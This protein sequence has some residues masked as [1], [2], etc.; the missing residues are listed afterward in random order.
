MI[1]NESRWGNRSNQD[2]FRM[3]RQE[4]LDGPGSGSLRED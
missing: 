2:Q 4:C 3:N 1:V